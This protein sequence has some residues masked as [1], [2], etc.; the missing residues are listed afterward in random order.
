MPSDMG[1]YI[2]ISAL[3]SKYESVKIKN[4][5]SAVM[6]LKGGVSGGS[7][8]TSLCLIETF[9][10]KDLIAAYKPFGLSPKKPA[11][12]SGQNPVLYDERLGGWIGPW[13]MGETN[14]A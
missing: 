7:I 12:Y 4:V 1:T 8:A 13:I 10:I 11:N 14:A 9:P 2:L 3:Q 5:K 6:E